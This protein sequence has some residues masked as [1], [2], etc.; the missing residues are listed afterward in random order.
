MGFSDIIRQG[1][2]IADG[3]T[4]D[5]Q[6]TVTHQAWIGQSGSGVDIFAAPVT[7]KALVDRSRK[8]MYTNGGKLIVVLATLTIL[9]P[10]PPT[11]PNAGQ[12][13]INPVDP[14]DV[15]TLDD[16]TTAPIQKAGGFEDAGAAPAPF[17]NEIVLGNV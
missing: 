2:A 11:T 4:V 17:L 12:Q 14:R 3:L 10:I 9:D 13:R 7:R 1:V 16:G 5:L 15:F 6:A 8:P